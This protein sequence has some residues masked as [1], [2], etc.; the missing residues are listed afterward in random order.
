MRLCVAAGGAEGERVG[1]SERVECE[2]VGQPE[3]VEQSEK[4]GQS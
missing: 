3:R 2:R 1:Q 4:A